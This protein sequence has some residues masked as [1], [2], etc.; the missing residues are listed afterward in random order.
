[1]EYSLI[2]N[3]GIH[4]LTFPIDLDFQEKFKLWFHEWYDT[5]D[6]EWKLE[7]VEQVCFNAGTVYYSKKVLRDKGYIKSYPEKTNIASEYEYGDLL[8]D[9]IYPIA[10]ENGMQNGNKGEI[11]KMTFNDKHNTLEYFEN[12]WLPAPYFFKRTEKKFKFGPLNWVRFKSIPEIA[13][14]GNKKYNVLVAFDT[15][16]KYQA[17]E[18]N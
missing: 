4:M 2:A 1:M 13:D 7:L 6:G 9:G 8:D 14:D 3:T 12:V 18:Y 5:N 10:D 11:F 16:T 17:D 15:R